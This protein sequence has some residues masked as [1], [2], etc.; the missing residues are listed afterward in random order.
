MAELSV[1][2][3]TTF[4]FKYLTDG[5]D[6]LASYFGLSYSYWNR[7]DSKQHEVEYDTNILQFSVGLQL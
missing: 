6:G 1:K 3:R 4:E 5:E 7:G 2:A